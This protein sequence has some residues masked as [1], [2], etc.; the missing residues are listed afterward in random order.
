MASRISHALVLPDK[1]F[2]AWFAA[3]N[4]Y[5]KAFARVSI[6]RSPAGY[7]LNLFRDVTAVEAPGVWYNDDAVSHIRRAYPAVVRVDAIRV[8]TPDELADVLAKR[9]QAQDRYGEHVGDPRCQIY[10]RFTLD[11]LSDARPG[12]ILKPFSAST[13]KNEGCDI[14]AAP[15]VTIRAGATGT[16]ALIMRQATALGYGDYAQIATKFAG[17]NYLVTYAHL[18]NIGVQTGQTVQKGDPIAQAAGQSIKLVVQKPGQGQSGFVLPDVVDPGPLIYWE[19]MVLH[20]TDN[21]LR[22]RKQPGTAF[23]II[24]TVSLSDALQPLEMHGITL[25]KVGVQDQWL[26]VKTPRGV[27]GFVAAWYIAATSDSAPVGGQPVPVGT[28]GGV[29]T[30]ITSRARDIFLRGKS[31]GNRPNVFSKIGDSI[32][33]ATYVYHPLSWATRNLRDYSFL[34]PVLTYFSAATIRDGKN[35]FENTSLSA[36]NGWSTWDVLNPAKA[37]P[38]FAKA[39]EPPLIAELRNTKPAVALIMLGTNDTPSTTPGN[40]TTNLNQ[41][42]QIVIDMGVIPV[43]STIP[44]RVGLDARVNDFNNIIRNIAQTQQIPLWDYW[45]AMSK[46]PNNGLSAD[47]THPSYPPGDFSLAG[48][49]STTNLQYGYTLRNL[50]ILEVLDAVWKQALY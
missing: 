7:N 50:T 10:D 21:N 28:Y 5:N 24:D 11:W 27:E 36:D 12:R 33:V 34:Q 32:T 19:D 43:I 48:D 2:E 40:Y 25:R 8:Q 4:A 42:V 6:F 38:L 14:A 16:V 49:L 15:G 29:I 41:I 31:L 46:L 20:P 26:Q 45:T 13:D 3:V 18:Q 22:V 39:G 44:S 23:D 1:N 35:S 30:N 17:E 47:G 9:V 37:N